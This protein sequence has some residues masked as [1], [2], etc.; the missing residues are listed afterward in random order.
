M[1]IRN[2]FGIVLLALAT[3]CASGASRGGSYDRD[4][5]TR[6]ELE[7][8]AGANLYD[9]VNSSRSNWLR[10]QAG[11][12]GGTPLVYVDGRR[13]GGL[14]LLRSINVSTV[15]EVRYLSASAA[16]SRYSMSDARPVIEVI[17]RG[18]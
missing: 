4:R 5:I 1:N 17:S 2:L 18:R 13:L 10:A 8:R 12:G 14:E 15:E 3:A 9:I 16:H 11:T 7:S 6:E